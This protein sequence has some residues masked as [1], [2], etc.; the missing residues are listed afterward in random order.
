MSAAG[1]NAAEAAKTEQTSLSGRGVDRGIETWVRDRE[2][3]ETTEQAKQAAV[4]LKKKKNGI[5]LN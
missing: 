2:E 4:Y 1:D 5:Q 3:E